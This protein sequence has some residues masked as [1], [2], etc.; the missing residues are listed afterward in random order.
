MKLAAPPSCFRAVTFSQDHLL[1]AG[2]V[3]QRAA[4]VDST[5]EEHEYGI[6][7]IQV[8]E[9]KAPSVWNLKSPAEIG[10]WPLFSLCALKAPS[11]WESA[12][13]VAALFD[14]SPIVF[15]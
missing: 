9:R 4:Q 2:N 6:L 1:R 8:S 3:S 7:G 10:M 12:L 11:G 13:G 5:G 14:S 15:I